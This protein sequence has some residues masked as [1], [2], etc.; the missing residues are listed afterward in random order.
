MYM[1]IYVYVHIYTYRVI[2]GN[3]VYIYIFIYRV[4]CGKVG[5]TGRCGYHEE[6]GVA[7]ISE[8]T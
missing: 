3:D 5:H 2:C 4:L 8:A 7:N 1:H 6:V